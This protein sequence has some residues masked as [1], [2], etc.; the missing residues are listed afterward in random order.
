MIQETGK[1]LG[2]GTYKT[3]HGCTAEVYAVTKD[4]MLVGRYDCGREGLPVWI[5]AVW[6]SDGRT[7]KYSTCET[8]IDAGEEIRIR[9]TFWLN[10]YP[11]GPGLLRPDWEQSLIEASRMGNEQPLCRV[12]VKVNSYIGEGL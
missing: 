5:G 6:R 3:R 11:S 10:I 2:V 9:K 8:D 7:D 12:E 1:V 4:G